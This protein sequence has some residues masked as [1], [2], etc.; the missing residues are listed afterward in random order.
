DRGSARCGRREAGP[1]GGGRSRRHE[2]GLHRLRLQRRGAASG[3][4]PRLRRRQGRLRE[5]P[6]SRNV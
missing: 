3:D 1:R 5:R 2:L 6:H 4:V